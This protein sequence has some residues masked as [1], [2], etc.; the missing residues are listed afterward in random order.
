MADKK[1]GKRKS[2]PNKEM[3]LWG[4]LGELR[5]CVFISIGTFLIATVVSYSFADTLT[6]QAISHADGYIFIQT[7]VAELMGQYI[8]VSVL[9]GLVISLPIIAWQLYKFV[10]PGLTKSEEA[11]F[12]S[13]LIGGLALFAVGCVFAYKL[14]IPFTLQFF[15]N[16]NT[17]DVE[18]LYSIK[19]Y[20]SYLTML[21][22]S[23]G[24]IFEIP[25][26]V[27]LLTWI[28]FLKPQWM[29]ASRRIV[30]VICVVIGAVITP[31]DVVSQTT[32]A[33][34]MIL[35]YEVGIVICSVIYKSRP[36]DEDEEEEKTKKP[37][38]KQAERWAA[39]KRIVDIQ[40]AEK[41]K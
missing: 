30:I 20:I 2:N 4:H 8:K 9:S 3:T 18:G 14:V 35:L 24:V 26:V 7:G 38:S 21:M 41:K 33:V 28:G 37:K 10:G 27:A 22:F 25:V 12:L 36:H 1:N 13:V 6:Q 39:A 40:D 11:K 16:I 29:K 19:E 17:I 34:P 5:T 31:P 23:F 15:R 32:V